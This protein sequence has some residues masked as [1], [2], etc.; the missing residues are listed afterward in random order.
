MTYL[1]R[2][3]WKLFIYWLALRWIPTLNLGDAVTHKG[4]T[5]YLTQGVNKPYWNM[6]GDAGYLERVHERDFKKQRTLANYMASYRSGVRF[7]TQSWY[8]IWVRNGIEP[9]MRG[10]DIWK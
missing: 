1:K 7:Y 9:W 6:K 3:Y 5:Y 8:S 2:I 10:C 4:E